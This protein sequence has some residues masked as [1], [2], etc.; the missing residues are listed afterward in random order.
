MD[1]RKPPN[2]VDAEKSIL[3]GLLVQP[4][5]FE[6]VSDILLPTDFYKLVHQ[7]LYHYGLIDI[8]L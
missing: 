6:I 3:G 1:M 7:K 2:N 4:E 5:A 8:G